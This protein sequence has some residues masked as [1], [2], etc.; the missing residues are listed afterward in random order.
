MQHLTLEAIA[1]LVDEAPEPEEA[2][3]LGACGACRAEL[4]E[5]RLQTEQLA[6]LPAP[7]PS[8]AAWAALETR[9]RAEGLVRAA[10]P[11]VREHPYLRM[12][13][14]VA[15]LVMGGAAG[16]SLWRG[17]G[18]SADPG[19][20]RLPAVV[21]ERPAAPAQPAVVEAVA[22]ESDAGVAR[23]AAAAER[24]APALRTEATPARTIRTASATERDFRRAEEDYLDALAEATGAAAEEED[25]VARLAALEA[26]VRST[27]TAL[28][29]APDDPVINGYHLAAM[30]ARDATLRQIVRTSQEAWY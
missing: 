24:D 8:P 21:A 25:P 6:G 29:R 22:P 26:V 3:H 20:A 14:S 23:T 12:A 15:I 1:R 11:G 7:E 16:M 27:R 10:A 9:L 19:T 2:L 28:D 30:G 4:A 17:G 5:M 13:A 18:G